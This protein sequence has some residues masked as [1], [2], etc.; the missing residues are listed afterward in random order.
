MNNPRT[1]AVLAQL[2]KFRFKLEGRV[3]FDEVDSFQMVH[4]IKYLYWIEWSRTEY[5]SN[6]G[7]KLNQNTFRKEF[8]IVTVRTEI[9]YHNSAAFADEYEVYCRIVSVKNSS[10]A[11]ENVVTLKDKTILVSCSGVLVHINKTGEAE[12][13]PDPIRNMIKEFEGDNVIF[14][15]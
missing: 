12:R 10:L 13:I 2:P 15:D 9:D 8:P 6:I 3:K 11:F 5:I 4:N 14:L 1:D 7:M